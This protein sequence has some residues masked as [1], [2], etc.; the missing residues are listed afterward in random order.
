MQDS[1]SLLLRLTEDKIGAD[2]HSAI[3][4]V[5]TS[6]KNG[7]EEQTTNCVPDGNVQVIVITMVTIDNMY[8]IIQLAAY[9]ACQSR[10]N[11]VRM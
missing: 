11:P 8:R 7:H 1:T 5:K 4:L 10:S 9:A 2:Q 3:L 6:E